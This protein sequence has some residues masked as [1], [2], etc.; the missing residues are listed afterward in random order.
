MS[1][2]HCYPKASEPCCPTHAAQRV[3]PR[4]FAWMAR[5]DSNVTPERVRSFF[6]TRLVHDRLYHVHSTA[7]GICVE[8]VDEVREPEP[9]TGGLSC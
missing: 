6:A 4:V 1:E 8:P 7:S 5:D 3:S 9:L 2:E